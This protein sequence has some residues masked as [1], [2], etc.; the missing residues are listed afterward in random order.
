M[1]N[2]IQTGLLYGFVVLIVLLS[3]YFT[4][5]HTLLGKAAMLVFKTECV[6]ASATSTLSY[7]TYGTATTTVTCPMGNDGA[8]TAVLAIQVNASSTNSIFNVY[9]EESMDGQDY[10]PIVANETSTTTNPLILSTRAYSTFIFASSTIGGTA[11]L[12]GASTTYQGYEAENN[13]NHYELSVPVRMKWVR[14]YAAIGTTTTQILNSGNGA[15]WMQ[16]IPK[17]SI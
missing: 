5:V 2:K 7:M 10:Y 14:A 12:L 17:I 3:A 13:R 4:G 15:V 6:T 8:D 11:G 1:I 16:I 9:V